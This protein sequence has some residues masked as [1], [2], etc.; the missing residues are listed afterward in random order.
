VVGVSGGSIERPLPPKDRTNGSAG[1]GAGDRLAALL[2]GSERPLA[3]YV[4]E[5]LRIWRDAQRETT[6]AYVSWRGRGAGGGHAAYLA[7][8]DREERAAE[9][10]AEVRR[11]RLEERGQLQRRPCG[12][13][14]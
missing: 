5:L 2:A 11:R 14:T 9:V 1:S 4:E 10:Y 7:A 8:L 3:D 12:T 6:D 13:G